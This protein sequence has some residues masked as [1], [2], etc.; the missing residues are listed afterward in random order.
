VHQTKEDSA[1]KKPTIEELLVAMGAEPFVATGAALDLDGT[2]LDSS[3]RLSERTVAAIRR[4]YAVGIRVI[5]ATGRPAR[6]VQQ[7]IDRLA[8][9]GPLTCVCFNG[10]AVLELAPGGIAPR[11]LMS[12]PM[13]EDAATLAVECVEEMGFAPSLCSPDKTYASPR[14]DE[15]EALLREFERKAGTTHARCSTVRPYIK[16]ALKI[17]MPCG[18]AGA[19]GYAE[20]AKRRMQYFA[21]VLPAEMHVEFLDPKVN[22]GA[23]LQRLAATDDD[24]RERGGLAKFIAIGDALNDVQMLRLVGLPIAIANASPAVH[25]VALRVLP[26][27]NDEDG[28]AREL[29]TLVAATEAK[30]AAAK[31]KQ[32]QSSTTTETITS[33]T[34]TT[35]TP[36]AT[37][38]VP[39]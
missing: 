7:F 29:E 14:T 22:K 18:A 3:G 10:A 35:P 23:A 5:I 33:T 20:V 15:Q 34:T 1:K 2:T 21:H 13:D 19:V 6:A 9:P 26:F 32:Q 38:T 4:A 30:H 25:E 31:M 36:M 24:I 12:T 28:V 16:D 37:E 39:N 17:V 27:T 8:L 11:V